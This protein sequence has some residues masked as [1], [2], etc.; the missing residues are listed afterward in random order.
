MTEIVYDEKEKADTSCRILTRELNDII[1]QIQP[2]VMTDNRT[3]L[4]HGLLTCFVE[5]PCRAEGD[6]TRSGLV[7]GRI[8]YIVS[9]Y[10]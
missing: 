10:L 3:C 9:L 6:G 2:V 7:R 8:Q 4:G 5:N 1:N